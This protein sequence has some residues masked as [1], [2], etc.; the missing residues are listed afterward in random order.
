MTCF[1]RRFLEVPAKLD[2]V[3][4]ISPGPVVTLGVDNPEA[5]ERRISDKG[6]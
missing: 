6:C 3:F 5:S 4:K 1:F 2:K